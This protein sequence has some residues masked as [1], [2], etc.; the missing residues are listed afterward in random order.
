MKIKFKNMNR[1]LLEHFKKQKGNLSLMAHYAEK[2]RDENIILKI[3]IANLNK[4]ILDIKQVKINF[5]NENSN[6]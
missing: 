4:K 6:S 3:R 1:N 2:M 5:E